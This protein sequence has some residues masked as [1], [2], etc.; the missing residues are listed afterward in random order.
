MSLVFFR[1]TYVISAN[2]I[3]PIES[4]VRVTRKSVRAPKGFMENGFQPCGCIHVHTNL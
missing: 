1:I 4:S 2:E 3:G